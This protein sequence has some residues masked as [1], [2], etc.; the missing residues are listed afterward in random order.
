[1]RM[2]FL[3]L[4]VTALLLGCAVEETDNESPWTPSQQRALEDPMNYGPRMNR[5]NVSGGELYEFDREGF[6]KDM[7]ILLLN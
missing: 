4:S 7:D 3:S 5:S 1:M 2:A 6:K